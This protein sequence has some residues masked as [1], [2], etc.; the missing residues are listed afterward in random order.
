MALEE[1][2]LKSISPG[3]VL[4]L[5]HDGVVM[6]EHHHSIDADTL[7]REAQVA[8]RESEDSTAQAADELGSLIGEL[9]TAERAIQQACAHPYYGP[10]SSRYVEL[11]HHW[12]LSPLPCTHRAA[13]SPRD[14]AESLDLVDCKAAQVEHEL[15]R[16]LR[17]STQLESARPA[18]LCTA[19]ALQ[20]TQRTR[21]CTHIHSEP[22]TRTASLRRPLPIPQVLRNRLVWARRN[23]RTEAPR[24]MQRAPRSKSVRSTSSLRRYRCLRA[25]SYGLHRKHA[26]CTAFRSSLQSSRNKGAVAVREAI[27]P[28]LPHP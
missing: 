27:G 22:I 20:R 25:H 24:L 14:S 3:L 23:R 15:D 10:A 9:L 7:I 11:R 26:P 8:L 16:I 4:W 5:V 18:T 6:S 21:T 1:S 28:N 13:T 2:F 19:R 17:I 12:A